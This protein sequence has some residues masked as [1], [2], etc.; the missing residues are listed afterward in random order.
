LPSRHEQEVFHLFEL[1]AGPYPGE[2]QVQAFAREQCTA[3]FA[4]YV[5]VS[6]ERSG[7]NFVYVWPSRAT[8][9]EWIR[10][11]GCALFDA[12]GGDLTGSMAGTRR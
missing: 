11:G 4:Q 3:R 2:A 9:G 7:L 12:V 1:P 8:W 10:K 5:G 6:P